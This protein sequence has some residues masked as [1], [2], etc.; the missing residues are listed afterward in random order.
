[1]SLFPIEEWHTLVHVC[2]R[3]RKIVFASPHRLNLRILC[4]S[5]SPVRKNLCIW[6]ALPI[7]TE[8]PYLERGITPSDEENIV[9]ALKHHDRVCFIVLEATS[10]QWEKMASVM[11]KPSLLLTY[12]IV[13]SE[14]GNVPVPPTEFLG[15]SAPCLETIE[16]CGIPFP[17]LPTLLLSASTL[18]R[19]HLS[20]IPPTGYIP[21][22]AM[23]VCLAALPRL[24]ILTIEFRL[25]TPALI[26]HACL[27]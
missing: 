21:L 27:P 2:R 9:A 12:L 16:F 8:Y 17:A 24:E 10:S 18:V 26:E 19:L 11:Q 3:W 1:M 13:S 5:G 14:D 6:P 23:V 25:S 7:L 22:E 20:K 15:G 4:K